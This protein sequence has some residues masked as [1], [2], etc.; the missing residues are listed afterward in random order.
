MRTTRCF[1]PVQATAHPAVTMT[2][3]VIAI[4]H[5]CDGL[6]RGG[7]HANTAWAVAELAAVVVVVVAGVMACA[8]WRF[9]TLGIPGY[10]NQAALRWCERFRTIQQVWTGFCICRHILLRFP[11]ASVQTT[12]SAPI[13]SPVPLLEASVLSAASSSASPRKI[14]TLVESL[15]EAAADA[16]RVIAST[17]SPLTVTETSQTHGRTPIDRIITSCVSVSSAGTPSFQ[18]IPANAGKSEEST[19]SP[20]PSEIDGM[21]AVIVD[22]DD[23]IEGEL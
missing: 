12:P 9:S 10:R 21:T 8:S 19:L 1:L 22:T 13:L 16:A 3:A 23:A 4:I 17:T 18:Q 6:G 2:T 15:A 14:P 5:R 7:S 11:S 20:F